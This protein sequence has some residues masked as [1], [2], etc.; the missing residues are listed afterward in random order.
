MEQTLQFG[1]KP[2]YLGLGY[3]VLMLHCYALTG[4][5]NV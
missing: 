1:L 3:T 2:V 4:L 5:Q